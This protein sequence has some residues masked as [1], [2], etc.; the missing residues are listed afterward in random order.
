MTK[1]VLVVDDDAN[2]GAVLEA[3]LTKRDF[4]VTLL[5]SPGDALARIEGGEDD[6]DVILTDYQMDGVSGAELCARVVDKGRDIPVI[7]MTSF[8]SLDTAVAAMRAGAFDYVT[9]PLEPDALAATLDRGVKEHSIREEMRRLREG[10]DGTAC[11]E[12]MVG[13]SPEMVK[14]F[15]LIDRVAGSEAT[16]LITGESG[17]G[18]ELAAKAIHARSA[19]AQGPFI[20][21]NCA[22]MPEPLLESELFGHTK[23]AFTDARQSRPGVFLQAAGGTLFLDEIGEM[24]PGMQVKL[25]RALQERT[26]RPVGGDAEIEF[27]TR[28]VAAT[29]RDLEHEVAEGRFRADLFYR[30]NVVC[31]ELPPLRARG[32]DILTLANDLLARCQPNGRRVVGFTAGVIDAMLSYPW[33]GNVRELQNTLE[34]AVA[35]ALFDHLT[36][37]DLPDRMRNREP[38]SPEAE[39]GDP[40]QLITAAELERRYITHVMATVKGN[41]TVAARILGLDRRTVYRKLQPTPE[42]SGSE[43]DV[44]HPVS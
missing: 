31:V 42:P 9:K 28:I 4:H 19:R 44:G 14:A 24:P 2:L 30:I 35:L 1:H 38:A 3:E 10:V 15:E 22:A 23:G 7:L 27:D 29:N 36:L 6:V 41:K 26:V 37:E 20:A 25:L 12:E 39:I 17:T 16:V 8:G 11:F 18:K 32:R 5:Q 21:I 40:E 33:P 34:R 13:E 43:R